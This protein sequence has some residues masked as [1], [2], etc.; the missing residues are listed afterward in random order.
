LVTSVLILAEGILGVF[1]SWLD[2][3]DLQIE[4]EIERQNCKDVLSSIA[5]CYLNKLLGP[6][7]E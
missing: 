4:L 1:N 3:S 5:A 2:W 6:Y 7:I